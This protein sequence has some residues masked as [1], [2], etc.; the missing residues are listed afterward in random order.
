LRSSKNSRTLYRIV[1]PSHE[2]VLIENNWLKSFVLL[3]SIVSE[4]EDEADEDEDRYLEL[5]EEVTLLTF[6]AGVL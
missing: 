3:A 4:E 6:F 2:T 1:A 5:L